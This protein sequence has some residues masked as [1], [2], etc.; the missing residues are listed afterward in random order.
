VFL[1]GCL[2]GALLADAGR[3]LDEDDIPEEE[4]TAA[5]ARTAPFAV[6]VR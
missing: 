4:P 5:T 1:V 3:H 6:T 2:R